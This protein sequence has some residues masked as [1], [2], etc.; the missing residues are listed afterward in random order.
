MLLLPFAHRHSLSFVDAWFTAAS[1]GYVTGLSVVTTRTAFTPIGQGIIALLIQIGGSGITFV[2]TVFFLLARRRINLH[3]RMLIAQDRNASVHGAVRLILHIL[4]YDLIIEGSALLILFFH[5][6]FVH[7]YP[8]LRAAGIATF[9]AISAFNNAGFDLW[10]NSLIGFQRDVL[11]ILITGLLIITGGLGFAVL[12]EIAEERPWS[13]QAKRKWSLHARVVLQMTAILLFV[14]TLIFLV[15]EW[16]DIFQNLPFGYKIL[17]AW[18][19]SVTTRTAGFNSVDIGQ[20]TQT[21]LMLMIILMFIGASPNSTGGGIKT[22]TFYVLVRFYAARITGRREVTSQQ[23]RLT[24][25]DVLK[26]HAAFGVSLLVV[27]GM[28][29][30]LTWLEPNISFLRLLFEVTSAFGTVGLTTGITPGLST[31][32]KLVLIVTMYLGRIGVLTFLVSIAERPEPKAHY[33]K[34]SMYIG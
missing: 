1:A 12:T 26:A 27:L 34:E 7:G 10:G 6:H 29:F 31:A 30:L 5:F 24:N 11:V 20:L 18:F 23:R 15:R 13:R 17:N 22:T 16:N 14:P 9:H 21:S 19:Q 25:E 28:V 4:Y 2:T 33:V 3:E 32:A 8:W